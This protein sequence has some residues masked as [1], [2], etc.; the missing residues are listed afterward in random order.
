[1]ARRMRRG[2]LTG[3][4]RAPQSLIRGVVDTLVQGI[5]QQPEHLRMPG[6]G[7]KQVNG[8]S[9][10]VD[11]LCK[12]RGL[13]WLA[14][15]LTSPQTDVWAAFMQV[16]SDED[17]LLIA[18]E[19]SGTLYLLPWRDGEAITI[20]A[21]GTG[22]GTTTVN[23]HAVL[24]CS[25]SGYLYA[26]SDLAS[27]FVLTNQGALGLILNREKVTA[28]KPDLSPEQKNEALIFIQ[29]VAYD[30]TYTVTLN[31]STFTYSTPKATDT[32]NKLSTDAV[33]AHFENALESGFTTE[34]I[35]A[36]LYI[37]KDDWSDFE[38]EIE[39]ERAN[40]LAR[41][42]KGSVD[43]FQDLPTKAKGGMIVKVESN[44]GDDRDDY[45]VVFERK[46][47]T[48]TSNGEGFWQETVAPEIPYKIDEAT[49][50]LVIR[51]EAENVLFIGPANGAVGTSGPHSFTFPTWSDRTAGTEETVPSP[52]FLG[53][54]LRDLLIYRSRLAVAGGE[55]VV[56]SE[57]DDIFNFFGDTATQVLET[58]P[59]DVRA[60]S[61]S[62]VAL[63]WL[64]PVGTTLMAFSGGEQYVLRSSDDQVLSPRSAV[65]DQ[66]SRVEMNT[67]VRPRKSGPNILFATE[68]ASYTGFR[69][70][71]VLDTRSAQLGLNLGGSQDVTVIV[72]KLIPGLTGWWAIGE[73]ED[74]MLVLSPEQPKTVYV[75][76]YLWANPGGQL[77]KQQS[78]WS[79][80]TFDGDVAWVGFLNGKIYALLSYADGLHLT[81]MRLEELDDPDTPGIY[82]D[83][84]LLFPEQAEVTA[85]YS[86]VTKR[87]TFTL[88]Y[89]I[90]RPAVAVARFGNAAYP[91][92]VIGAAEDG[93]TI[94]CTVEGDFTGAEVAI[95]SRIPF[96][97]EFSRAYLPQRADDGGRRIGVLDGRL[98]IATWAVHYVQSGPFE[99]TVERLNREP[100]RVEFGAVFP[101]IANNVVDEAG[102]VVAT[103]VL[104]V[105]VYA[106][107]TENRVRVTSDS[108]LPMRL[109]GA[110]WEG[111]YSDRAR[112]VD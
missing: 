57:T 60:S 74:V 71:Q 59:I 50:P 35:G 29:G 92:A 10:V 108:F 32:P 102:P 98:Q 19:D 48:A 96:E 112:T 54:P 20:Q 51:R 1:M 37:R 68:E 78:S 5:S 43:V 14:K 25:S 46:S 6:Q 66:L 81:T 24:T 22:L 100:S 106:K 41:V 104:R 30:V 94:E 72:P 36:V 83:R 15:L 42:I 33:A 55:S 64:T 18:W 95:G 67:R 73:N 109:S 86:A 26:A 38:I 16:D 13:S 28:L 103:G 69:E 44:P 49:M 8:W 101:D 27:K 45:W 89:V 105:P 82:L 87:T 4:R 56:L 11:G 63:E 88:P 39:D 34:Q 23:G 61:D 76:K 58:D 93:S 110:A 47:G 52:S 40:T 90:E 65:L 53:R 2:R 12:R 91:G 75:Y 21:Q 107:N 70:Y 62:S 31:G 80:W 97:Y 79:E 77:S 3:P 111:N 99:V 17:Y 7:Q 85:A 84:M 9:S